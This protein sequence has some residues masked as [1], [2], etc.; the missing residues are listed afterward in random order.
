MHCQVSVS[1]GGEVNLEGSDVDRPKLFCELLRKHNMSLCCVSEH[2]WRGEGTLQCGDYLYV[3]SGLPADAP[4]AMQGVAVVMNEAMQVAWRRAGSYCI[5][6]GGRLLHIKLELQR[7]VVNVISVY[8]PVTLVL[9]GSSRI[10]I[11]S[12]CIF[13][14]STYSS[15]AERISLSRPGEPASVPTCLQHK[16]KSNPQPVMFVCPILCVHVPH[17]CRVRHTRSICVMCSHIQK[18]VRALLVQVAT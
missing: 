6:Y 10:F 5:N 1:P 9:R 4:K 3:F 17:T 8:A 15:T 18:P 12:A 14:A 7:R 2:R 11:A 13:S 16:K